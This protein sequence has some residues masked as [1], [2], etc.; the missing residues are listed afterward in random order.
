LQLH[1]TLSWYMDSKGSNRVQLRGKHPVY[2]MGR[3][4]VEPQRGN[5]S[6]AVL[7]HMVSIK[8]IVS[9]VV[10]L[11]SGLFAADAQPASFLRPQYIPIGPGCNQILTGDFNGDGKTDI[12]VA[13]AGPG[14]TV[15][16]G[17]GDGTFLRK[18]IGQGQIP[19]STVALV[20]VA[21]F[22]SDG[23]LD[24]L[25]EA[26]IGPPG[27][28]MDVKNFRYVP[29][30]GNGDGTF[31][32]GEILDLGGGGVILVADFNG[33]GKPDLLVSEFAVRFGKGDGSFQAAGPTT[34]YPEG[35]C[36]FVVSGDFNHDGKADIA[37]ISGRR[38]LVYVFIGN[39]DGTFK[40]YAS[41]GAPPAANGFKTLATGDLNRDGN[42][43]LIMGAEKGVG[44]LLGN[45]DGTFRAGVPYLF[46]VQRLNFLTGQSSAI[47]DLNGDGIPDVV[48][49]FTMFPGNGD[50]TLQAPIDFGQWAETSYPGPL[51]AVDFNGDGKPDLIGQAADGMGLWFLINNSPGTDTSVAAVSSADY[52]DAVAPG[53][54]ATVFGKA[55]ANGT[56]SA[57]QLPLPTVLQ[58]T[59]VRVLDQNGIERLAQLLYVS[60]TQINFLV[61]PGVPEGYVII[62]VDNGK[63]PL[64]QGARATPVRA[65]AAGFFTVDGSGTGL[66]AALAVRVHSDG[67]QT[68][69]P[70]V[71]CFTGGSCVPVPIDLKAEGTVY[72]SVYGTG[73][74]NSPPSLVFCRPNEITSQVSYSG[75]QGQF[76]GLDQ[77]NLALAK[78][79]PS[80][81]LDITCGFAS[82]LGTGFQTTSSAT[83]T[84]Y[85]K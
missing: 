50:G 36:C 59:K 72:L 84:V 39:G 85:I 56:A 48:N 25:A 57:T 1:P 41:Y 31:R 79:F 52:R 30:L 81:R 44:V 2:F 47:A 58:N 73:F 14:F 54:L 68:P 63:T 29:L 12:A 8:R 18:D 28:P 26:Y 6:C 23:I 27:Q 43:D 42:L 70:V 10:L 49:G 80:G 78:T 55:L 34:R 4:H 32:V 46:P 60:P 15:M 69:V 62:N 20:A 77:L 24:I 45:G 5:M 21:D 65:A 19:G 38:G 61:P 11:A 33:D 67:S 3:P 40:A 35:D 66:P 16:L 13:H 51:A 53:S 76:P 17:K 37:M 74:D 7:T 22:N 75:P 64:I 83:F 9:C 82:P 71:Q